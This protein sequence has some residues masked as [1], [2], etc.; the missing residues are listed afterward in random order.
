MTDTAAPRFAPLDGDF[1]TPILVVDDRRENLLALAAVLEPLGVPITPAESGEEALRRLLRDE[2]ALILLD[3]QMPGLSGFATAELIKR[4]PRTAHIPIIFLTAF[5]ER[6]DNVAQGYSSGAVDYIVKP[7]DPWTLRSKVRV[8]LELHQK[9]V[10]LQRQTAELEQN[11]SQLRTSRAALADAQRIAQIGSWELDVATGR[12]VG[13]EEFHRILGHPIDHVLPNASEV[14]SALLFDGAGAGVDDLLNTAR[15]VVV[16][17]RLVSAASGSRQLLINSEPIVNAQG[18]SSRVIGT[19]QDVTRQRE[20][21][22]A[23]QEA[24]T[25]LEHERELVQ[26]L[27]AAVAPSTLPQIPE[28]EIACRYQPAEPG[29]VG[30]DWYDTLELDDGSTLLAIGDVAGHGLSAAATM[31]QLRTALR[32]AAQH[33]SSPSALL[34]GMS[35]FL[36]TSIPDAFATMLVARLDQYSGSCVVASAGH[37]PPLVCGDSGVEYLQ[38]VAG[39]PIS[40]AVGR[41]FKESTFTLPRDHCLIFYT[42]GLVERR[43]EIIDTG[44]ARL[45]RAAALQYGDSTGLADSVMRELF[46]DYRPTDDVAILVAR[47]QPVTTDLEIAVPAQP[48]ELASIRLRV[49]RWLNGLDVPDDKIADIVLAVSELASNSCLHAYPPLSSGTVHII[50]SVEDDTGRIVV[51]DNGRWRASS[52]SMGGRGLGLIRTLGFELDVDREDT[53]T[54]AAISFGMP[55]GE[56]LASR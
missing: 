51:R 17:A 6:L 1:T 14:F 48:R 43:G 10:M 25:A 39:P 42:D 40:A 41:R 3:V 37:L 54:T 53:G 45:Q 35:R 24:T 20:A 56:L 19:V 44:L 52:P 21:A 33:T 50:G 26:R 18:Q 15:P 32:V 55:A 9:S 7:F 13:S 8:F 46:T 30:G 2:F 5:D 11:L 31:S 4:H 49:R 38:V 16:E 29:F 12:L 36:E 22:R 47:R 28:F 34:A 27:Q 23:L